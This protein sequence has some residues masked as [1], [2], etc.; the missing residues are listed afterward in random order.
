MIDASELQE[1]AEQPVENVPAPF[2]ER[3]KEYADLTLKQRAAEE[4]AESIAKRL[5]ELRGPLREEMALHGLD[6]LRVGDYTLY[7]RTDWFVSKK[8]EV[9]TEAVCNVLKE[10][11]RGDMVAEAYSGSSLKAMIL[12]W[13]KNGEDVP[14]K[15]ADLLN[16]GSEDNLVLRKTR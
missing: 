3:L 11:G 1:I 16:I 12:E 7:S 4:E 6:A 5:A 10:I 13:K 14:P 8:K 2:L 9:E 15:L